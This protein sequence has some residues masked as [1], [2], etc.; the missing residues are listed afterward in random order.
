ML[1]F[2]G[3]LSSCMAREAVKPENFLPVQRITPL[4]RILL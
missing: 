3:V 2:V 1:F 4:A